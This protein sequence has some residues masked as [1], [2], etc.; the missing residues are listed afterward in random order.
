MHIK[1]TLAEISHEISKALRPQDEKITV[2]YRLEDI[3]NIVFSSR[4]PERELSL[5]PLL[6]SSPFFLHSR[7]RV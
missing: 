4:A 3:I 1:S 7:G 5:V 2:H 6:D